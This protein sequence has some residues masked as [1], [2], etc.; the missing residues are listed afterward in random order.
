MSFYSLM[1]SGFFYLVIWTTPFPSQ[2]GEW[3]YSIWSRSTLSQCAFY[4]R[5][6]INGLNFSFIFE[7][8][9]AS[10]NC[11]VWYH[12]NPKYWDRQIWANGADPDQTPQNAASDQCLHHQVLSP[13]CFEQTNSSSNQLFE[14]MWLVNISL[15]LWSLNMAYMLILLLKKCE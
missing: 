7:F 1:P 11:S 12:N 15:K 8:R 4:W 9:L 14:T 6:G 5:L 2:R 10:E 13:I 3:S